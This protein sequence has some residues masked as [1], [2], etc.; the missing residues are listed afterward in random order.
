MIDWRGL[1]FSSLSFSSWNEQ[2]TQVTRAIFLPWQS[3]TVKLFQDCFFPFASVPLIL[4][5]LLFH[6]FSLTWPDLLWRTPKLATALKTRSVSL[7]ALAITWCIETLQYLQVHICLR[8]QTCFKKYI[9]FAVLEGRYK[10]AG[11]NLPVPA[12]G[13]RPQRNPKL[14]LAALRFLLSEY[15]EAANA[16]IY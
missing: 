2:H 11:Y 8:S 16:Y 15:L 3:K 12:L 10:S 1:V 5:Y 7:F 4:L 9:Y 14:P 13:S 6:S